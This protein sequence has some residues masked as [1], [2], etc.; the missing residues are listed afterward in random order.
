MVEHRLT[1]WLYVE[2]V[3]HICLEWSTMILSTAVLTMVQDN[4]TEF[5]LS[6]ADKYYV[7]DY[8]YPNKHDFLSPYSSSRSIVV[9]YHMS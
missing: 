4:D 3:V 9:W 1:L 5:L 8:G 6:P 7:V 2:Y